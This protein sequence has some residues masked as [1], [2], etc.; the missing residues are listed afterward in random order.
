[1]PTSLLRRQLL[2]ALLL[3]AGLALSPPVGAQV[4]GP[5]IGGERTAAQPE[6]VAAGWLERRWA[7]SDLERLAGAAE[8]RMR[9]LGP[10]PPGAGFEVLAPDYLPARTPVDPWGR[11]YRLVSGDATAI[12]SAGPDRSFGTEDDLVRALA[13]AADG[14]HSPPVPATHAQPAPVATEVLVT[15]ERLRTLVDALESFRSLRGH[16]PVGSDSPALA[17]AL[18]PEHLPAGRFAAEDAWGWPWRYRGNDVGSSYTLVS[19][20][21]D[22]AFESLVPLRSGPVSGAERDLVVVDGSFARWPAGVAAPAAAPDRAPARPQARQ[23]VPPPEVKAAGSRTPTPRPVRRVD[24]PGRHEATLE[25]MRRIARALEAFRERE[26]RYPEMDD[27]SRLLRILELEAEPDDAWGRPFG[28]L[29]LAA[30]SR[31]VLASR[32]RD[33]R[34]GRSLEDYLRGSEPRGDLIFVNGREEN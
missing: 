34:F 20:G 9:D 22:G 27:A 28:Y 5:T 32:G 2:P 13:T 19:A 25:R 12:V 29:S 1:M 14:S 23:A 10:L 6:D 31:C 16:Y 33:G 15:H 30:G 4:S 7:Q 17:E 24:E 3:G 21:A 26:G 8:A 18:V 11:P